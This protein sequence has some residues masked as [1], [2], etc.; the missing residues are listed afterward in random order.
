MF[1]YFSGYDPSI[2]SFLIGKENKI[3]YDKPVLSALDLFF[4]CDGPRD[5]KSSYNIKTKYN[6]T[7]NSN[8]KKLN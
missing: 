6:K 3:Q 5:F 1:F 8:L 4:N 2:I 7:R